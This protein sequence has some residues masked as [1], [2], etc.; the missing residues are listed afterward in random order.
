MVLKSS[1]M[2]R[3]C[4]KCS[5]IEYL[6]VLKFWYAL[7]FIFATTGPFCMWI[8]SG[9]LKGRCAVGPAQGGPQKAQQT[10]TCFER[11]IFTTQKRNTQL[12]TINNTCDILY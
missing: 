8:P 9:L 1:C 2:K 12:S 4:S 5:K 7:N 10:I 11:I 6:K 3:I